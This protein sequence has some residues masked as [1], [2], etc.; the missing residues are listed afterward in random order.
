[1]GKKKKVQN[2]V[3]NPDTSVQPSADSTRASS[4]DVLL[5]PRSPVESDTTVFRHRQSSMKSHFRRLGNTI[6]T[7]N[8]LLDDAPAH[9]AR[10]RILDGQEKVPD[11]KDKIVKHRIRIIQ[12]PKMIEFISYICLVYEFFIYASITV[13]Y[14]LVMY[15]ALFAFFDTTIWDIIFITDIIFHLGKEN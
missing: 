2:V 12:R 8:K 4:R 6:I 11:H 15:I 7:V 9:I 13:S 10:P 5:S 1:M 14:F 3:E